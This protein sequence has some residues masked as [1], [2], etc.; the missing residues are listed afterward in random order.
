M[1]RAYIG[2]DLLSRTI[3]IAIVQGPP[4]STPQQILRILDV[5]DD[6]IRTL[7]W[8]DIDPYAQVKPTLQLPDTEARALLDALAAHYHGSSETQGLRADYER[9]RKRVDKLTDAVIGIASNLA[10][11]DAR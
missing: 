4:D 3:K 5:N 1:I 9:E 10:E 7:R 6:G 2:E 8:D 11:R